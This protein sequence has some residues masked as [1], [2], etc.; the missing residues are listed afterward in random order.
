MKHIPLKITIKKFDGLSVATL[1]WLSMS[2]FLAAARFILTQVGIVDGAVRETILFVITCVPFIHLTASGLFSIKE[3]KMSISAMNFFCLYFVAVFTFFFSLLLNPR[4][5]EFFFRP[6][7]GIGPV[8][9]PDGAIYAFL[10]FSLF[11]NPCKIKKVLTKAA[12]VF[13][14]FQIFVV[15]IPAMMRGYWIDIAP[16]GGVMHS[17][18]SLSFGYDMLLPLTVFLTEG[19]QRHKTYYYI[20]ALI[21]A[22]LIISNGGRGAMVVFLLFLL[23]L[24]LISII[25][26]K[27]S[28][29][30]KIFLIIGIVFFT[31]TFF[32]FR[33]DLLT[34]LISFLTS[35]KINS[36][37]IDMLIKGSF[38]SYNGRDL[39]WN[40]V[41]DA[42]REG[43]LFG[44]GMFGDRPFVRPYHIAGYSHNLFLELLVSF[45]IIGAGIIVYILAD[46]VRMIFFCK[47]RDWRMIYVILFTCSSKLMLSLS[48]WYVWEFWAAAAIAYKYRSLKSRNS[49]TE[50]SVIEKRCQK[51]EYSSKC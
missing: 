13:F 10:L 22:I 17:R 51:I 1:L 40:A 24:I 44:Y 16:D 2:L 46:A 38:F 21:S 3:K 41:I 37:S 28:T 49:L 50:H 6:D 29:I 27:T 31:L 33:D 48:F 5:G 11:D 7:Y 18:Y 35:Q 36:R 20:F 45:G 14:F 42:I 39:I 12:F 43:G 15:F 4:L 32:F 26:S 23:L 30:K 25:D 47:D 8:F 34:M 19:M 9:R